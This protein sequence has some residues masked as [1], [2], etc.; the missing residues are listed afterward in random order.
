MATSPTSGGYIG[1]QDVADRSGD[2]NALSFL[3]K[4]ALGKVNTAAIVKVVAVTNAGA[5]SPVGF[6]DVQPLVNQTDGAGNAVPHGTL[7]NL[8]YFRL[9]GGSN[10]IIIDPQVGDIGIAVFANRDISSVK[11]GKGQANP[12]SSRRHDMADGIYIGGILN[13][14]PTQFVQFDGTNI[15]ITAVS[16]IVVNA[17]SSI[18]LN[19]PGVSTAGNFVAGNGASGSTVDAAGKVMTFQDGI[20]TNIK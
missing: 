14:T 9:Q 20:C 16:T 10:A 13:G 3:V 4:Q 11:S 6:V 1:Q 5:L 8:P 7:H 2:F 15:T 12:G 19:A 17:A 18:V